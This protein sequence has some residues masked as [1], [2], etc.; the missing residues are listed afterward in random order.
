MKLF[1]TKHNDLFF[2]FRPLL[3]FSVEG[4][5]IMQS[6]DLLFAV[7]A[8]NMIDLNVKAHLQWGTNCRTSDWCVLGYQVVLSC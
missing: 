5:V 4:R 6:F 1:Y 7:S 8:V 2:S 3:A